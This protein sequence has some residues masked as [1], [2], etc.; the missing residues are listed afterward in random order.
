MRTIQLLFLVLDPQ[1]NFKARDR[2]RTYACPVQK[3]INKHPGAI[4]RLAGSEI[5]DKPVWFK[6][7]EQGMIRLEVERN[8]TSRITVVH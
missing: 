7:S 3:R 5:R 8:G 2:T 4:V 1:G 6:E